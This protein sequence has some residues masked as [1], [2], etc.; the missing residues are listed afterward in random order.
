VI[1]FPA[2]EVSRL[3]L[4]GVRDGQWR[5]GFIRFARASGAPVLPVRIRA[6]NSALF[7]GASALFKPAGTALLARETLK[8]RERRLQLFVGHARAL[9]AS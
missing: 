2:G 9:P 8:R 1:V 7:Y 3:G 6:R 4:K 5:R